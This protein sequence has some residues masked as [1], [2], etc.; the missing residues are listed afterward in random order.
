MHMHTP[1]RYSSYEQFLGRL[2]E[3][4]ISSAAQ[5]SS[6][7]SPL[8]ASSR[9]TWSR[10]RRVARSPR[11]PRTK[12]IAPSVLMNYTG[13]MDWILAVCIVKGLHGEEYLVTASQDTN[14]TVY[15]VTD[16]Q[17]VSEFTE[18]S[19]S[20]VALSIG[21]DQKTMFSG[22]LDGSVCHWTIEDGQLLRKYSVHQKGVLAVCATRDDFYTG[23]RGSTAHRWDIASGKQTC[24][25]E[26]HSKW[27]QC[28]IVHRSQL[29]TGSDDSLIKL[30]DNNTGECLRTFEGHTQ[31]VTSLVHDVQT[32]LL[33]SGSRQATVRCWD[34]LTGNCLRSFL[35]HLSVV[36]TVGLYNGSLFTGSA[37][38]TVRCWDVDTADCKYCI[39][40]HEFAITSLALTDGFIITGS[41][42]ATS[43]KFAMC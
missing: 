14:A 32:G 34:V 23:C 29:F 6:A 16:A 27:V 7:R 22:S 38:G 3:L 33:Y 28:L 35:G 12:S 19:G 37:D 20:V 30:W 2:E 26:G 43:R 18:H 13:H 41:S 1:A 11:Q 17:K 5:N 40:G 4:S 10:Q 24:K 25:Y 15:N 9:G 31:E 39:T 8:S 36:R 42:D 21:F